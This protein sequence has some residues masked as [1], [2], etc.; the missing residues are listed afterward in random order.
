MPK[1]PEIQA[2]ATEFELAF[3]RCA[4]IVAKIKKVANLMAKEKLLKELEK[5][6]AEQREARNRFV[7]GLDAMNEKDTKKS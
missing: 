3:D 1:T 7:S 6:D 2:L 4:A 5:C